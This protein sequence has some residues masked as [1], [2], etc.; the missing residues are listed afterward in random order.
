[1][2]GFACRRCWQSRA[3][4][5]SPRTTWAGSSAPLWPLATLTDTGTALSPYKQL[6][7]RNAVWGS[8]PCTGSH[9]RLA[10]PDP[11]RR[12][13]WIMSAAWVCYTMHAWSM[14][15]I[16]G[17]CCTSFVSQGMHDVRWS[18]LCGP[19]P[20]CHSTN[21]YVDN[22]EK[23]GSQLTITWQPWSQR[24]PN[25]PGVFAKREKDLRILMSASAMPVSFA[26]SFVSTAAVKCDT[27][28]TTA[29]SS[30]SDADSQLSQQ[31]DCK[32]QLI[33]S[34][35]PVLSVVSW[36]L[37]TNHMISQCSPVVS[38]LMS[39]QHL[40]IIIQ[41][42]FSSKGQLNRV[43]MLVQQASLAFQQP[44]CCPEQAFFTNIIAHSRSVWVNS[45]TECATRLCPL[46]QDCGPCIRSR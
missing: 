23:F 9:V 7:C 37:T 3:S 17:S 28:F 27:C 13:E 2:V 20:G 5:P 26:G 25:D 1:M 24:R 33:A 46:I 44:L 32:Q 39:I 15:R 19:T 35:P 43:C 16:A 31:T 10:I 34:W 4:A 11:S 41:T 29:H 30:K 14:Q 22:I 12:N 21:I 42:D 8:R 6:R 38:R 36:I 18:W 45:Q 40:I